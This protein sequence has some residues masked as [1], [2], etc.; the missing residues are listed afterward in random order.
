MFFEHQLKKIQVKINH[1]QILMQP[2]NSM[3]LYARI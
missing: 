1:Y 3:Q 2:L